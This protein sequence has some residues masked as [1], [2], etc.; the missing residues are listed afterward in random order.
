M[1]VEPAATVA[2][3]ALRDLAADMMSAA[4]GRSAPA[5]HV[6]FFAMGGSNAL[7]LELRQMLNALFGLH[8]PADVLVR[9]PT[10]DALAHS[11]ES[12]WFET[13]GSA[14]ELLERIA[15]LADE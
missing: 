5:P 7:A 12:A 13:G 11:V 2:H 15:A 6:S 4:T 9:S 3:N 8:L 1:H 14:D 10:P